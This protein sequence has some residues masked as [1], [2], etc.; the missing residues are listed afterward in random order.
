MN[1]F[2][3]IRAFIGAK[4]FNISRQF[5]TDLGC[6]EVI[7]DPKMS[8]FKFNDQLGFYLQDYRVEDWIN[9]SMMFLGVEHLAAYRDTLLK[10]DLISTYPEVRISEIVSHDWGEV[11]YLHDPSTVLWHIG[12]FK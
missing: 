3:S 4:D 9:N 8:Y 11:F 7:L 5:Y 12:T 6:K 2:Q 1:T 10:K